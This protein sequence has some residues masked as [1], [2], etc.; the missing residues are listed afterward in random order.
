[1]EKRIRSLTETKAIVSPNSFVSNYKNK[2][3]DSFIFFGCWND[4]DCSSKNHKL[5][6][7][8]RDIILNNINKE[9]ESL[10]IVGGDNWYSQTYKKDNYKYKYYP[11]SVLISGYKQLLKKEEK[12]YEIILGNHDEANDDIL[13]NMNLKKDCMLKTQEYFIKKIAKKESI[14]KLPSLEDL[15]RKKINNELN[16][17]GNVNLLTCIEKPILK[18]LKNDVYVLYINT[19]LFDNY[20]YQT[21]KN[22][23]KNSKEITT[24][25]LI[26]YVEY[27]IKI[28]KIYNP[29]L[30]FVVGHNPLIA[31]KKKK[32]HK[33][34]DIY[35]DKINSYI[36]EKMVLE[37]NKYKTI[38]LCADVHNFN[39]ALLNNN[40]GTVISGTGGA[41]SLDLE[42][43]EGKVDTGKFKSPNKE[44]FDIKDHYI[45]NSY[46]YTKI[47]YD[48]QYNVYVTY[49]QLFNVNKDNKYQNKIIHK[50]IK[51]YNF[52]FKNTN[53]GWELIKKR[54]KV[55]TEKI[56]LNI[57]K[58]LKEKEEICKIVVNKSENNINNLIKLNQLIISKSIKYNYIN[59]KNTPLLCY[60][61]KKKLKDK[62]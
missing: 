23:D 20:T 37:L 14:Y 45:Y 44:L 5:K 19:N 50:T 47:K 41:T 8:Y 61:N 30:L 32:Y 43:N 21:N 22:K 3:I 58:L 18:E 57:P 28:L 4:V 11:L 33:L 17:I 38:Y 2:I 6:P 13:D 15:K 49:K 53:L 54:N 34:S 10:V 39:I 40:I 27:I 7:I 51:K 36:I 42:T 25:K 62:T 59:K 1:M 9:R 48:K 56:K 55:S 31:Y 46:G 12:M 16:I 52:V 26:S 29:K 60:Y 35:D 24:K